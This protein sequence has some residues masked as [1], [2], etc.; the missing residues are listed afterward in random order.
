MKR[1]KLY[2][3]MML[4]CCILASCTKN[5]VLPVASGRPYEVLVVLEGDGH[6]LEHLEEMVKTVNSSAVLRQDKLADHVMKLSKDG[7]SLIP[8]ERAQ[9]VKN[10]HRSQEAR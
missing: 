4:A 5:M 1:Y 2:L 6:T 8:A 10:I 7:R 9:P 3:L